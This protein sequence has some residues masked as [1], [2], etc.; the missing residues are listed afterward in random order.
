M[1]RTRTKS[2]NLLREPST[3][4]Y[5]ER[6]SAIS[7]TRHQEEPEQLRLAASEEVAVDDEV[8]LRGVR[9]VSGPKAKPAILTHGFV[10]RLDHGIFD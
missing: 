7:Q 3:R 1:M 9:R 8:D 10:L 2:L 6:A 5:L 4:T